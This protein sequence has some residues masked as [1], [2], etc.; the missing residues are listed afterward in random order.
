[1][2]FFL[3]LSAK[4]M[5]CAAFLFSILFNFLSLDVAEPMDLIDV[6]EYISLSLYDFCGQIDVSD[7]DIKKDGLVRLITETLKSDPYLFFV[8]TGIGYQATADGKIL[9]LYP[10]YNMTRNEYSDARK[11]CEREI[12]RAL[13]FV[14]DVKDE[15]DIAMYLHDYL[16][17]NFRYDESLKSDSMYSFLSQGQGTCQ[18]YTYTYMAMLRAAGLEC[19]FVA[20]DSM[21]HI[22]NLVKIGGEWYHVDVTWDDYPEIFASCK[23]DSFLKSDKAIG[24]TAHR[25]W[26][27]RG[28]IACT[29]EEYD[30][31]S[32]SSPLS[33]FLGTGDVSCDGTLDVL[34]LVLCELRREDL[35]TNICFLSVAADI[36]GDCLVT[37][38]DTALIRQ[39][40]LIDK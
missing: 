10:T 15:R 11:F 13:T 5:L 1:M 21:A 26:Y 7:F 22:W 31:A 19:T 25:D 38:A 37:D 28:D 9:T 16:C 30:T 2:R 8:N 18:G 12:S 27:S 3:R 33:Q 34:D 6:R 24:K 20:S 17:F 36:D 32:F 4:I 23:Y 40:I 14:E 35:P 29:S 39:R